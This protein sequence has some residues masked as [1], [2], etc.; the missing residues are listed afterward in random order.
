MVISLG[1]GSD[2]GSELGSSAYSRTFAS[3]F[4]KLVSRE[5]LIMEVQ[6]LEGIFCIIRTN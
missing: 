5:T 2:S 1:S 4:Q 6:K 3:E